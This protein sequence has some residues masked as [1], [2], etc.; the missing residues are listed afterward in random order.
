MNRDGENR[1]VRKTRAALLQAFRELVLTRRYSEIRIADILRRADVGRSTFYEH[2]RNKDAVLRESLSGI[3][4]IL[5]KATLENCDL[6][7]LEHVLSHF[8]ENS[9]LAR[10]LLNG[11]SSPQVV[12]LLAD[13]I[14]LQLTLRCQETKTKPPLPLVLVALQAAESQLGLIRAWLNHGS[15]T[16]PAAIAVFLNQTTTAL[17]RTLFVWGSS[18]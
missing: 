5:A 7:P 17:T 16:A 9:K 8:R 15:T 6:G 2:F 12:S 13:L 3:V 4:G 1:Q 10:G 11:P 14:E 18:T